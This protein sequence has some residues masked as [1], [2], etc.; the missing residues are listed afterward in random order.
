MSKF[1]YVSIIGLVIA[2]FFF[3]SII[4]VSAAAPSW[5]PLV[6]CGVQSLGQAECTKCDLFKLI[7]NL[8]DFVFFGLA[9]VLGTIFFIWAGV[10]VLLAGANVVSIQK[11]KDIFWTTV[12]ALFVIGFAW[13]ITNTLIKSLGAEYD[14]SDRWYQFSCEADEPGPIPPGSPPGAIPSTAAQELIDLGVGLSTSGDCGST[15]TARQTILA[16]AAGKY[17]PVCSPTCSCTVGGPSGTITVNPRLL[18]GLVALKKSGVNFTITSL[19]TGKH[20]ATS[21]H[22]SG[23]AVDISVSPKTSEAWQRARSFLNG[24]GGHAICE[25]VDDRVVKDEP[26]CDL[27]KVNHIHWGF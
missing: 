18:E 12:K 22:Y 25:W 15:F 26:T 2:I 11:G 13:L 9:P 20:S 19:T 27:S 14:G 8:I 10:Q 7:D 21:A 1:S 23:H 16:I 6:P 5:W 3:A 4:T 24:Y 17:P